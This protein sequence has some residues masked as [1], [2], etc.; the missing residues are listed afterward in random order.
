MNALADIKAL[1][2]DLFGTI[3]DLGGSLKPFISSFLEERGAGVER[4]DADINCFRL[5]VMHL[6]WGF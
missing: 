4:E 3:L 1:T 5:L 6:L 2:F